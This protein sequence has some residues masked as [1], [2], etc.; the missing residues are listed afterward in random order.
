MVRAIEI[1]MNTM[2]IKG[3]CSKCDG[4]GTLRAFNHVANGRCFQCGGTGHVFVRVSV[5]DKHLFAAPV[6][7][8]APAKA[9]SLK[10]RCAAL[11]EVPA[12]E[13]NPLATSR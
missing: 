11:R 1:G 5:A 6:R 3:T 7:P 8:V 13:W 9:R 12:S 10:E 4:R 2:T